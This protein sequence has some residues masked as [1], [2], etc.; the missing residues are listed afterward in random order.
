MISHVSMPGRDRL[1]Q[2]ERLCFRRSPVDGY[3]FYKDPFQAIK[4]LV[5]NLTKSKVADRMVIKTK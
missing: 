4:D 1:N 3:R 2:F 5:E